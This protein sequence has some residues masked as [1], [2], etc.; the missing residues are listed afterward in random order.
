[1]PEEE[2]ADRVVGTCSKY[3]SSTDVGA[4]NTAIAAAVATP[5]TMRIGLM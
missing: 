5:L 3:M 2:E 1:M 4:K